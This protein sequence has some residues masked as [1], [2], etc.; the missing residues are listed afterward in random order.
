MKIEDIDYDKPIYLYAGD[1]P[2]R[3]MYDKFIGLSKIKSDAKHIKH[4]LINRHPI[5][6]NSV[7][8]YASEDVFEHIEYKY[9]LNIINDIHRILKPRGVF[10]LSMPDY[11]CDILIKRSIIEN[12]RVIKDTVV[13][14]EWFPTY[15]VVKNLLEK[16]LFTNINFLHYY[17]ENGTSINHNID[18]S[19]SHI[20]RTPDH[21][22]RVKNPYR[23]LSVVVDCVK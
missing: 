8:I 18:Y 4:N 14:H 21:D 17:D 2:D 19:I 7:D 20:K 3:N 13:D 1:I 16:S 12:G 22:S 6:D 9:I 11:A 15:S 10:R 23:T 5:K